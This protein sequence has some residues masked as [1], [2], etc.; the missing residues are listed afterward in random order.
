[1]LWSQIFSLLGTISIF[2]AAFTIT[3]K[4][5]INPKV[6]IFAF[7]CYMAACLFLALFGMALIPIDWFIVI[8]QVV[9]SGINIRG[10]YNAVKELRDARKNKS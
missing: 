6:R 4:K 1:M 9:L 3:S 7:S 8:Q 10:M 2:L 5:A